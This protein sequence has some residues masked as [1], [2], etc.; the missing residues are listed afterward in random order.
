M[1]IS[2]LSD[3]L[4]EEEYGMVDFDWILRLFH[5]RESIEICDS[6]YVRKVDEHNL[7]LNK[8]YRNNDYL[9]SSKV[10]DSYRSKY[11][12]Q[13]DL[14]SKRLNGSMA[15]YY[16]LIGEMDQ[17]RTY[18]RSSQWSIKTMLYYLTTFV[19]SRIVKKY[20]NVFG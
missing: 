7:S 8:Q 15:R 19:G 18:F 1:Y 9:Y 3:I 12:E 5:E 16:Y 6:L 13:V 10:I 4:F 2:E 14:A 11:P 20:F 17:A